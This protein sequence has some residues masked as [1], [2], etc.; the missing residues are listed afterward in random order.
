M[1]RIYLGAELIK[2]HPKRPPGGRSTDPTDY[3]AGKAAWALRKVD[4]LIASAHKRSVHVGIYAERLL[5]V[6][7]PWTRMRQGYQLLRLC[8]RYGN[9]RVDTLC[10]R[11]LDFEVVDVPR[12]ARMLKS[13]QRTEDRAEDDGKLK[14]L[15]SQPRF[16][17]DAAHFS[18]RDKGPGGGAR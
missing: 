8:D 17:R 6:P 13:A 14:K 3:P 11:A 4:S 16:G 1:V 15:P 5:S 9:D 10:R 12:I 18:T 7:L 2:V